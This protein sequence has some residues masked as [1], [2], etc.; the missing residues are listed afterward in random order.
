MDVV[1]ECIKEIPLMRPALH[2]IVL[3]ALAP[4]ATTPFDG[5]EDYMT[6]RVP[7]RHAG[8]SDEFLDGGSIVA[9]KGVHIGPANKRSGSGEVPEQEGSCACSCPRLKPL[10]LLSTRHNK[11]FHYCFNYGI[12][13]E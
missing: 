8:Y 3:K 5:N 9:R 10:K 4:D 7:H 13:V 11:C 12:M 6:V 1:E 2:S